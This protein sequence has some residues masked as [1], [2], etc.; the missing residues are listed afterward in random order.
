MMAA[1]GRHWPIRSS[2]A[3]ISSS[4]SYLWI[5]PVR[6][7]FSLLDPIFDRGDVGVADVGDIEGREDFFVE[8]DFLGAHGLL[9]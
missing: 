2:A 1:S 8:V 7:Q 4:A 9:T 6:L 5:S 3:T